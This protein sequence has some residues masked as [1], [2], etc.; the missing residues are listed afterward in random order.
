MNK[1]GRFMLRLSWVMI[2]RCMDCLTGVAATLYFSNLTRHSG[3]SPNNGQ[4]LSY[5][6]VCT[7]S[8][9]STFPS[10]AKVIISTSHFLHHIKQEYFHISV[11]LTLSI[12]CRCLLKAE[13]RHTYTEL[14][15]DG[16]SLGG[17]DF[18]LVSKPNSELFFRGLS[19]FLCVWHKAK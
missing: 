12:S 16:V 13:H 7:K 9:R 18:V 14:R 2:R 4:L 8:A 11:Y 10:C 3:I 17:C 1:C 6:Y 5:M 15:S 19:A